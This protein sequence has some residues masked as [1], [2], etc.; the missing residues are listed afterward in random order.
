MSNLPPE[1]LLQ[2]FEYINDWDTLKSLYSTSHY[3]YCIW[4]HNTCHVITALIENDGL[5]SSPA[6]LFLHK[7]L[8]EKKL[9][10]RNAN[11]I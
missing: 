3:V 4:R 8:M 1:V 11:A 2:I 7:R 9:L 5:A 6:F 10:R